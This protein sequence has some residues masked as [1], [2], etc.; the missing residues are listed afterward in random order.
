MFTLTFLSCVPPTAALTIS[1]QFISNAYSSHAH[2][3]LMSILI[4][5]HGLAELSSWSMFND[6]PELPLSMKI[7]SHVP[8]AK[9]VSVL[10]DP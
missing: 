1:D 9:T 6:A 8:L 2:A 10:P 5:T 4:P 7:Q 3:L